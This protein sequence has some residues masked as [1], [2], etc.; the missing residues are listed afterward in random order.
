M[1][2]C[3]ARLAPGRR[4]ARRRVRPARWRHDRFEPLEARLLLDAAP[5][6]GPGVQVGTTQ[7]L[8]EISGL[9]VSRSL[10]GNLWVHQDSGDSARFYGLNAA[11]AFHSTITLSGAPA[12]DWE[13]MTI[14]AKPGGGNYL[15]FADIGDNSASRT[16][17]VDILRVTEPATTG[18][19]TLTSA[20]YTVK[21]VLY[22]GGPRNAE[23]LI[24]D[25]L[26]G[27]LFIITKQNP[28]GIYRLPASQFGTPGTS[29]LESLGNIN[30]PLV[31]PTA[32]DMSPDGK[33]II[34]RNS[35]GGGPISYLFERGYGQKVADA[36]QG[37]PTTHTLQLEP[38]GEAIG[39]SPDGSEF[40]SISEGTARPVWKY[41]F[42]TLPTDASA[43]GPYTI[44]VGAGLTL[45]A[46]ATGIGPLSYSWDV[47]DDGIFGDATGANPTL[48]WA[49][50]VALGIDD[51]PAMRDVWVQV[52]NGAHPPVAASSTLNVLFGTVTG[53]W[54]FYN[55]SVWDDPG[56][57]FTNA[58]AIAADKTA[59][60][61]NGANTSTFASMSSYTKGINGIMV[62]LTGAT[63]TLTAADFTIRISPQ[64]LAANNAPSTW[65]AAPAFAV[66][67]VADTPTSGTDRYELV[68]ADGAITN[69]YVYVVVEGN[70]ALGGNNTNTGLAASDYFFF[71]SMIGDAGAPE[72]YP[73]VNATDQ[74]QVRSNQGAVAPPTGV[75]NLY[76]FNRDALIDATDQIIARSNQG[77][78]PWLS[79]SSPPSAPEAAS[80]TAADDGGSEIASAL[81]SALAAAAVSA[82]SGNSAGTPALALGL[83]L[84]E[85]S[86]EPPVRMSPAAAIFSGE[87]PPAST[88][89]GKSSQKQ[90]ATDAAWAEYGE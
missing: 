23:S 56:F 6:V 88:I 69:R 82:P 44:A 48:S 42:D 38:Q 77:A 62:E 9:A 64:G 84:A 28:G 27:D 72:F 17:G 66:T 5:I 50:L 14:A 53:R 85:D 79:L 60:I 32:A 61:P 54:L 4:R 21:R 40:F 15:Y 19:A 63:G 78:M 8:T 90:R 71:G 58:S 55:N 41:T 26:T 68:W 67:R 20:D 11:G 87:T 35:S 10:P 45:S 51:P 46:S 75:L 59:Y 13:D 2:S 29:T 76:D 89:R 31:N 83:W 24:V 16:S 49:Q 81:A 39:W 80:A 74:V 33:F 7:A 3:L 52:D 1:N 36:L 22:P 18:N 43:G 12:V 73:N 30:A 57:G 65:A 86:D 70:D 47:N 37:T 34:V 25:P